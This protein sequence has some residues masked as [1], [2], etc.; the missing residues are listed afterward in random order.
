MFSVPIWLDSRLGAARRTRDFYRYGVQVLGFA[1][2][3]MRPIPS[4]PLQTIITKRYVRV[5]GEKSQ[6]E[7]HRHMNR[8][9]AQIAY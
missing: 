1:G 5:T 4:V 8:Q 9:S 7:L 6:E 2:C 3:F